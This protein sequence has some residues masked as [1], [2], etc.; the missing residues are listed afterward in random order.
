MVYFTKKAKEPL[1]FC[2][3]HKLYSVQNTDLF[4]IFKS[5]EIIYSSSTSFASAPIGYTEM[6]KE[7]FSGDGFVLKSIQEK[8]QCK[9]KC[10]T[11]TVRSVHN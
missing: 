10:G 6:L 11:Y 1:L 3:K 9:S 4:A 2:T 5:G 8:K 7:I